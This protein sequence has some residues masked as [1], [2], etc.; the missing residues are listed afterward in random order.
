MDTITISRQE[1]IK[2]MRGPQQ[3]EP[4]AAENYPGAETG[5]AQGT[6]SGDG[7]QQQQP[8]SDAPYDGPVRYCKDG[9]GAP[10]YPADCRSNGFY[11]SVRFVRL[12][13]P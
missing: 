11:G 9:K 1:L 2:L 3:R 6:G 4:V 7:A 5:I 13:S 12:F 8:L 10:K